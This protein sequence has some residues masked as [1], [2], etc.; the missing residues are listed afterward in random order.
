MN[1]MIYEAGDQSAYCWG[2]APVPNNLTTLACATCGN[3]TGLARTVRKLGV[4]P[5]LLVFHCRNCSSSTVLTAMTLRQRKLIRTRHKTAGTA[6]STN[7][8]PTPNHST[9]RH[10][11]YLNP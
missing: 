11:P 6:S 2:M 10:H 7:P 3:A 5:E 1:E 4:L 8:Y 9:K